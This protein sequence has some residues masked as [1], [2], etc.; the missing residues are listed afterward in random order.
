[1]ST[2]D[3]LGG[4]AIIAALWA[5][6]AQ[7]DAEAFFTVFL[8]VVISIG[9]SWLTYKVAMRQ[10]KREIQEQFAEHI[11]KL[12]ATSSA[13]QTAKPRIVKKD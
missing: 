7:L 3:L 12:H 11:E 2:S 1:M 4:S 10:F 5:F 9:G 13:I 8:A 6:W